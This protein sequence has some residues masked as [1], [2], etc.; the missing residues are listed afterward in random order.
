MTIQ[1][2]PT[3]EELRSGY[4]VTPEGMGAVGSA[5]QEIEAIVS[6][7]LTS[8][9]LVIVGPCSL[10]SYPESIEYASKVAEWRAL[11]GDKLSIVMRCYFEKPRTRGGWK[12][13]VYDPFLDG[14]YDSVSGLHL[15][16]RILAEITNM[17]VPIAHEL[18]D[19]VTPNYFSDL[20]AWGAIGARTV[21]S[22]VHR[23][24]ASGAPYPVGI[25]NAT[26]GDIRVA[27]DAILSASGPHCFFGLSERNEVVGVRTL[28]NPF[29]HLVLRGGLEPNFYEATIREACGLLE[30]EGAHVAVLVD[31]SH[32][33]S[34]KQYKRQAEVV[35]YLVRERVL[36]MPGLK[37]I[38]LESNIQDGSQSPG[39]LATLK[40]GVSVTDGCLGLLETHDV[41]SKVYDSL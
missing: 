40:Y 11:F 16:R 38:M 18:L 26:S 17:G 2:L 12:G 37:G 41:I 23:Q 6:G 32:A 3:P 4:T 36:R 9:K 28:G 19:P 27:V 21:E 14:S 39:P 13:L 5:R 35:D 25:K 10:H 31:C 30:Q 33:N 1:K 7:A 8:K 20:I 15:C 34:R 22:Q 29:G 24:M